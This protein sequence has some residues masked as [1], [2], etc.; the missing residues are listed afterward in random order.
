MEEPVGHGRTFAFY[1]KDI[2]KALENVRQGVM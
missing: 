2:V 1:P